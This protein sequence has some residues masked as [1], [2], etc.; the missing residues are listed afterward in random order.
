MKRLLPVIGLIFAGAL[1]A[2]AGMG[3]F[4]IKANA[5]RERLAEQADLAS[6]ALVQAQSQSA[7]AVNEAN[8]KISDAD[9]QIAQA[10]STIQQMEQER[11]QLAAAPVL[12][13]PAPKNV[14]GWPQVADLALGVSLLQ[15]TDATTTEND[16]QGLAFLNT[17][18]AS[19]TNWFRVMPYDAST[20]SQLAS[21]I[22]SSTAVS[23]AIDGRLVTGTVGTDPAT[24]REELELRVR[25]NGN[26]PFLIW[27][28]EPGPAGR[29][30]ELMNVLA[31]MS[32]AP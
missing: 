8:Q 14:K 3:L 6:Q 10:Q 31:S 21:Q 13:P 15:P 19:S 1:A 28:E 17:K 22:A 18:N 5:D 29:T 27:A 23:Y 12:S 26:T 9:A 20:D 2:A 24:G 30:P 4:L 7:S 16:G 11:E 25:W 32:F